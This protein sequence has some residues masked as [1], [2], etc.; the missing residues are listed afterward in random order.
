MDSQRLHRFKG[1]HGV[2]IGSGIHGGI[3]EDDQGWYQ[4]DPDDNQVVL[5]NHKGITMGKRSSSKA[6]GKKQCC[7]KIKMRS[8][9]LSST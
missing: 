7:N 8:G 6:D 3:R 5:E 9:I 2:M 4:G 1:S